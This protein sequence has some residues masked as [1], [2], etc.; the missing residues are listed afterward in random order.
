MPT[1]IRAQFASCPLAVRPRPGPV[2]TAALGARFVVTF[3]CARTRTRRETDGPRPHFRQIRRSP[4]RREVIVPYPGHRRQAAA[5]AGIGSVLGF[6]V[7]GPTL[8]AGAVRT[9]CTA[10]DE[11][12]P[13]TNCRTPRR[14]RPV[15]RWPAMHCIHPSQGRR[16]DVH[17]GTRAP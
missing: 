13:H 4:Q 15:F 8:P 11:S 16:R 10:P 2:R 12:F 1:T 5:N 7:P 6:R 3:R 9:L 14:A 17:H